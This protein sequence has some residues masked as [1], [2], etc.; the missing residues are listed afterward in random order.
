MLKGL[1]LQ[2]AKPESSFKELLL[3]ELQQA[4]RIEDWYCFTTCRT[5]FHAVTRVWFPPYRL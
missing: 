3:F 5:S 2:A 1:V 4:D